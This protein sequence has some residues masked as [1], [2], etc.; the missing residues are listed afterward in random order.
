MAILAKNAYFWGGQKG[1]K[2][3]FWEKSENVMF[4]HSLRLSFMQKIRKIYRAVFREKGGKERETHTERERQRETDPNIRVLRTQSLS[5]RT[6]EAKMAQNS[7]SVPP[8]T[9]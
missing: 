8:D 5:R 3:N 6:K 4:L 9:P 2:M 7:V 1:V